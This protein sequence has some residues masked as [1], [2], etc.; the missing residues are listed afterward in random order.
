LWICSL[1]CLFGRICGIDVA[2][3]LQEIICFN[4]VV[5]F[6]MFSLTGSC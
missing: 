2:S 5:L 1:I 4:I 3:V 6:V